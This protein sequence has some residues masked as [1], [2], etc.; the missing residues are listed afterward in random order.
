MA[1]LN[2]SAKTIDLLKFAGMPFNAA[3]WERYEELVTKYGR[4]PV[5]RKLDELSRRDYIDH[6]TSPR[7]GWLTTKGKSILLALAEAEQPYGP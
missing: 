5:E 3:R 2:L 6:G 4:K 1:N 7:G